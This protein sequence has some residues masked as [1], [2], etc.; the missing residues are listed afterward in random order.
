MNKRIGTN[1]IERVLNL[2]TEEE[3][4]K[5][6][7]WYRDARAFAKRM[8]NTYNV[9]RGVAIAVLAS[10]SPRNK[11]VR[12]LIDVETCLVAHSEGFGPEHVTV[13][14]FGAMK[15]KAFRIIRENRPILALTSAKVASFYDNIRNPE[16]Q[17]VTVD[18]HAF[19]IFMGFR[20]EQGTLTGNNYE[21][22]ASAYRAVA[23]KYGM[24]PYEV[25]AITWVVWQRLTG[26]HKVVKVT[27]AEYGNG[28]AFRVAA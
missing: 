13:S 8:A 2:A 19:S 11:W 5:G 1:N 20:A 7:A 17:E 26:K 24:R 3:V 6:L 22:I 27:P 28:R 25:Q 12:N 9:S 18:I 4:Q 16:S 14:T 15:E 21:T 10:L 23:R